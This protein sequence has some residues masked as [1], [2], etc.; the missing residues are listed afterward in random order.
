ISGNSGAGIYIMGATAVGNQAL[1][2]LVGADITGSRAVSNAGFGIYLES[3]AANTIGSPSAGN[4]I[5]ANGDVGLYILGSSASA[6]QVQGNRV[7]T[8]LSGTSALGNARSGIYLDNTRSNIIGGTIAGAANLVCANGSWGM[9]ITN[10]SWNVVRGNFIGTAI[11]GMSPLGNGYTRS[12][13]HAIEVQIGSHDN[14][15]GG[16]EAG[17]GNTIAYAPTVGGTFYAGVRVRDTCTN[18]L[19]SGNSIFANGGLG[20]DLGVY[21]VTPNDNCDADTGANMLQ[22][23]PVLTQVVSGNGT[24]IRGTLN[25][26]ANATF[27]I[28]FFANPT[29]D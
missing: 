5:S 2:N 15:I 9:M 8:D 23:F 27:L 7:G 19:I 17:A 16:S 1:G 11:D 6:N 3:A 21:L 24:G 10:A 28:Q 25:S 29:C 12:G 18:N 14:L 20:I 22:N 26:K 13:F 4:V